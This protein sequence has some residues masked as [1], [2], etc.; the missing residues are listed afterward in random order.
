MPEITTSKRIRAIHDAATIRV[1][2]AYND[3]IAD[4]ALEAQSFRAPLELGLW[5]NKRMTWIKPSKVWMAYRCGFTRLKKDKNQSRVLALDI[6]RSK[7]E[8]LLMQATINNNGHNVGGDEKKGKKCRDSNVVVQWD[9]E[10]QI[11]VCNNNNKNNKNNKNNGEM[12]YTARIPS[13]KSIQIG[14]RGSAVDALL[15]PEVVLRIRDVTQDFTNA[16]KALQEE[17]EEDAETANALLWPEEKEQEMYVPLTI[18][19]HLG[20]S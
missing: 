4:A 12:F 19:E 9:P 16:L 6:S 15:D 7:L 18:Q 3:K 8:E 14:L 11:M 13:V 20:M 2:Q 10:R 5:S 17:E 1:Y